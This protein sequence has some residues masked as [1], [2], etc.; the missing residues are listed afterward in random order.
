MTPTN[1]QANPRILRLFISSTF[2]DMAAEREELIKQVFP[3]LQR[4][5][6][7]RQVQLLPIDLR[8]GITAEEAQRGD[9]LR[10]CLEQID[11]CRPF[12]IGLL[13]ERYGWV[14][15]IG[16]GQIDEA[17]LQRDFGLSQV[18]GKSAT[19]LEMEYAALGQPLVEETALFYFRSAAA[20]AQV[21]QALAA[22]PCYCPEPPEH[23]AK[24]AQLKQRIQQRGYAL[25][26][27][28]ADAQSLGQ[29]I[30]ADLWRLCDQRFPEQQ[31]LS[32]A[33]RQELAHQAFAEQRL[34]SHV[35]RP[36]LLQRLDGFLAGDQPILLL[37]GASGS[38]KSALLAHWAQQVQWPQ[39][40]SN[41][42]QLFH[43]VGATPESSQPLALMQRLIGFIH[44]R[45]LSEEE[46]QN[47]PVPET[48]E[49]IRQG[50][51]QWLARVEG[52]GQLLWVIDGIERLQAEADQLPLDW[53]PAQLP[54]SVQLLLSTSSADLEPLQDRPDL[55]RLE[56]G[57]LEPAEMTQLIQRHLAS[58]GKKLDAAQTERILQ[59]PPARNPL[60]LRILLDE[61]R[62]FGTFELLNRK[63]ADYLAC[64]SHD[65]LYDQL[66]QR[67]EQD[68]AQPRPELVAD[69]MRAL[70]AARQGLSEL[71]LLELLGEAGEPLAYSHWAPLASALSGSL[72]NRAGLL[73][74][75]QDALRQAVQ[76][77]YLADAADQGQDQDQNQTQDQR[78]AH[79]RLAAYFAR[80]KHSQRQLEELSWQLWQGGDWLGL[81][82]LLAQP[83]ALAALW[84]RNPLE[85]KA[86]WAQIE[87]HSDQRLLP[88]YQPLLADVERCGPAKAELAQLLLESG[89]AQEAAPLLQ[90]LVAEYRQTN[91]WRNLARALGNQ[92][93]LLA[94]QG[95]LDGALAQYQELEQLARQQ[96][97]LDSLQ[98]AL[99]NRAHL[100]EQ[101][102]QLS[103]AMVLYQEKEQLCRQLQ[104]RD[105][106]QLALGNQ[107]A[108]L[109]QQ[110]RLTEAMALYQ[111][112]EQL[113]RQ[114][115]YP[116]ALQLALAHQAGICFQQAQFDQ[117]KTRYAEAEAIARRLGNRDALQ[118]ILGQQAL[119][120]LAAGEQ[121]QAA[122]LLASARELCEEIHSLDGLQRVL[123]GEANLAIQQGDLAKAKALVLQQIGLCRQLQHSLS[124]ADALSSF[125]LICRQMAEPAQAAAA[126]REA[127]EIRRRQADPQSLYSALSNLAAVE[128]DLGEFA[129]AAGHLQEAE[130]LLRQQ[131]QPAELQKLLAS[132]GQLCRRLGD[133][134]Q[135]LRLL[136]EQE[137]LCHQLGEET[138]LLHCQQQQAQ[139]L[140]ALGHGW[141]ARWKLQRSQ[142]LA[143]RLG[144]PQGMLLAI[145][146]HAILLVNSKRPSQ[147][148]RARPLLREALGLAQGL[149][150]KASEQH[151]QRVL[152]FLQ[153]RR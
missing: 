90:A 140:L 130:P 20:S 141:R 144:E 81:A 119:L 2:R 23:Q 132:R 39:A 150:L 93:N 29:M 133:P 24:L 4:R 78:Q 137:R 15:E 12:F 120:A 110:G 43:Y 142:A 72:V 59:H 65:C 57:P 138:A 45:F 113:C 37:S 40:A 18:A 148:R 30:L 33:Q 11:R 94:S 51:S 73:D 62:L 86:C 17:A 6:S 145:A 58:F 124:L 107:A 8:W 87:A 103:Q 149:G 123:G 82:Q 70:W 89:Y 152:D 135:A 134:R 105:G 69:L 80:Q 121:G 42:R 83:R 49:A 96:Q 36:E 34:T 56:L 63:M 38:G 50:L 76:Q 109:Q 116:D 143:R 88:S 13:G 7:D 46:R 146:N 98:R 115:Q 74:F 106:L 10:L 27:D 117:A 32:P 92:A 16:P 21:E 67:L 147:W 95:D 22:E 9:V 129:V 1:K 139:C 128:I 31:T 127:L 66:L 71:E 79:A 126:L 118:N 26:Q 100:L 84:R 85:V 151:L 54:P 122:A 3:E 47:Q 125:A 52:R 55:Q 111:Q 41:P 5:L 64:Q 61:L 60:F 68:Y 99:G 97:D 114:L 104:Q 77:R 112:Q 19:E 101:Q 28:Y 35:P 75:A 153:E 48:A 53:L 131:Q 14:P 102:A 91:D 25:R 44:E 108:I 136:R